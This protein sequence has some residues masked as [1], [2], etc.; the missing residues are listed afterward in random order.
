MKPISKSPVTATTHLRP[1]EE[2]K[3]PG[4]EYGFLGAALMNQK[5]KRPSICNPSPPSRQARSRYVVVDDMKD[6]LEM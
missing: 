6:G 1:I 5:E 2:L 4:R 3:N